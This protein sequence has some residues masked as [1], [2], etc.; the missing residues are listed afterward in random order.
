MKKIGLAL[1]G[2]G[3]RGLAHIGILR[4]FERENIPVDVITGCSIGAIIGGL[5]AYF[6]SAEKTESFLRKMLSSEAI[7][8]L[9]LEIFTSIEHKSMTE[10]LFDYINSI[11][12]YFSMLKTLNQQAIYTTE[13]VNKIF[14]DFPDAAI[15]D[16][17]VRFATIATDLISGREIV[18][19]EGPLKEAVIASASIPGIF[20]PVKIKDL[21]LIDGGATDTI[22]VQVVKGQGAQY[23]VAV[24]VSKDIHDVDDL[25]NGLKIIYRAED[26]VTWHLT[27]ERLAGVDVLISPNVKKY[28]WAAIDKMDE[29]IEEGVFAAENAL[30][31]LQ[32]LL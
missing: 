7:D 22:P 4:V 21:L 6:Q 19:D 32:K 27:Q 3:A 13:D 10:Q 8:D 5:Y 24:D 14:K 12:R 29:I 26:I 30:D 20:P 28:S 2:G 11:R 23:V 9:D 15:K 25:D 17:D 18:L 1:G 16:L 31:L